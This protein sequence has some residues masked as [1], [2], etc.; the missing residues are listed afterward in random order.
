MNGP[1]LPQ[2]VN[3][4][5]TN[6]CNL[7][8]TFCDHRDLKSRMRTGDFDTDLLS[9]LLGSLCGL[10][11]FELGLVGLGEPLLDRRLKAHLG[12]I[13]EHA[14]IF[15]RI[16]LNTNAVALTPE[17]A[18]LILGS[19]INLVTFSLNATNPDAYRRL[20]GRD[21]F[22]RVVENIRN[23]IRIRGSVG[24]ND[25]KIG[26]QYMSSEMNEA[27][28]MA[29]IFQGETDDGIE[30]YNRFVYNKPSLQRQSCTRVNLHENRVEE[31]Y[32]CW[33]MYSRVY[34]DIDGNVYPC[35][36]GN[37]CYRESSPLNIG[38]IREASLI[39]IFNGK[40]MYEARKAAECGR[41]PFRECGS[42]SVW[43]L[44]PNNFQ[45]KDG[46]W[47]QI[48]ATRLRRQELDREK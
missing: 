31:R 30:I 46:R 39:S 14:G 8:C 25:L 35:T 38:N 6:R 27:E 3:I 45:W 24:R 20:M 2:I 29:G 21:L 33:S 18:S 10:K 34:I 28:E 9:S 11:I 37:D 47:I 22:S 42:C 7:E 4:E 17:K 5:M 12:V 16:S 40:R 44:L 13:A 15:T 19:D 26:I 48:G 36:I 41:L 32:P 23:F 1:I 43:S